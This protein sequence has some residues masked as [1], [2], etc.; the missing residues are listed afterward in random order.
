MFLLWV[1]VY[2]QLYKGSP[3]G[4]PEKGLVM[5]VVKDILQSFAGFNLYYFTVT[6]SIHVGLSSKE[7]HLAATIKR[8]FSK[9]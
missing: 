6:K 3:D 7:V 9:G 4:K 8:G 5:R 2:L 1:S